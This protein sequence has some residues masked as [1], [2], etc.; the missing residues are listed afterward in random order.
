MIGFGYTADM[1]E[2]EFIAPAFKQRQTL[3]ENTF[4]GMNP[5][6]VDFDEASINC[7]LRPT[8]RQ[9]LLAFT[10]LISPINAAVYGW[11]W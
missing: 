11:R 1:P 5:I 2:V 6:V 4:K 8:Q 7:S 10:L 3:V 9:A